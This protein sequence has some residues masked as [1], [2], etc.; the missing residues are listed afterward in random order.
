M[1]DDGIFSYVPV[2]LKPGKDEWMYRI[3]RFLF[4][5]RRDFLME[6]EFDCWSYTIYG[7]PNTT[8]RQK[9]RFQSILSKRLSIASKKGEKTVKGGQKVEE[10]TILASSALSNS[11]K[12]TSQSV[13]EKPNH[14]EV[15]EFEAEEDMDDIKQISLTRESS[16]KVK[17]ADDIEIKM[18]HQDECEDMEMATDFSAD[19]YRQLE[20][21]L[22]KLGSF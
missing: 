12:S 21:E 15:L 14:D 6:F 19:E 5:R 16:V 10:K 4:A 7:P 8:K 22:E 17:F 2:N 3:F 18:P 11:D 13:R 9:S 1:D 20:K